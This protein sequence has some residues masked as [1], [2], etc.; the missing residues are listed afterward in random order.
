LFVTLVN[1]LA[2]WKTRVTVAEFSRVAPL[3]LP[4]LSKL[5]EV[6]PTVSA[7]L[8]TTLRTVE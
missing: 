5:Y 4:T 6:V 7:T 8:V 2:E 1:R 3:S